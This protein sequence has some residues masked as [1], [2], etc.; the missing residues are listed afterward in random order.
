VSTGIGCDLSQLTFRYGVKYY[1]I[2]ALSTSCE[3][4]LLSESL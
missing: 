4:V 2:N 1:V 3:A